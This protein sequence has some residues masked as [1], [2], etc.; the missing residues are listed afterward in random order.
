MEV[1][2]L[3]DKEFKIAVLEN[4]NEMQE[5]TERSLPNSETQSKNKMNILPK[6][7]KC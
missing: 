4:L 3:N 7:L 6:R 1:C 2:D 5:N